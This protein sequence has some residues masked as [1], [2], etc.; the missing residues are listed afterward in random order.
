M[1]WTGKSYL[2]LIESYYKTSLFIIV[3]SETQKLLLK[4][5]LENP[6]LLPPGE[7]EKLLQQLIANLGDLDGLTF[8]QKVIHFF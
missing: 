2:N 1:K 4:Q 3:F 7:R 5:L 6:D 8:K